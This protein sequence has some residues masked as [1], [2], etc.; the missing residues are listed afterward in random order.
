MLKSLLT[1][2]AIVL[3]GSGCDRL[4]GMAA[5]A[6]SEPAASQAAAEKAA[7]DAWAE[8][9][10]VWAAAGQCGDYTQ[11]WI[12]EGET[13]HRHEMHCKVARLELIQK[14]VRAIAHCAVEGDDDGVD[15]V[16]KFERQEDATLSIINEA[17]D[18]V[19]DGLYR[20]GE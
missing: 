14:G 11:E 13:F 7:G 1:P 18:A 19:T 10:G 4:A 16:F 17:N 9:A 2:L 5:P 12:I 8:I 6:G 15:D 20:C 3:L